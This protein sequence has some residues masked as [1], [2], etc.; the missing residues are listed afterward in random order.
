M[1]TLPSYPP[2]RVWLRS[3][4]V[5]A[6]LMLGALGSAILLSFPV[7]FRELYL[8]IAV[9][10]SLIALGIWLPQAIS[11]PYRLWNKAAVWYQR[12]AC[13]WMTILCLFVCFFAARRGSSPVRIAPPRPGESLW[14]RREHGSGSQRVPGLRAP[15]VKKT[16][17]DLIPV[18]MRENNRAVL[19]LPF[20]ALLSMLEV[21]AG[22]AKP[23]DSIYT[24]Y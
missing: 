21:K 7:S 12:M 15:S 6:G 1:I 18:N 20:F 14:V 17:W 16:I 8:L 2:K 13:A 4:G 23:P 10:L 22:P 11:I 19:L 3:F 5:A 24:L 9:A